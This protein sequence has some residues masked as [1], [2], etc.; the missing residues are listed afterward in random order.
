VLGLLA[1]LLLALLADG[2]RA[3]TRTG[4]VIGIADG[5][6]STLLVAGNR[7][8]E[9]MAG[10]ERRTGTGSTVRPAQSAAEFGGIG[11]QSVGETITAGGYYGALRGEMHLRRDGLLSC[12]VRYF[13]LKVSANSSPSQVG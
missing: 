5:D 2:V 1:G 6:T 3:D 9:G 7:P 11:F 4:R 10:G 12:Q 8:G 13:G